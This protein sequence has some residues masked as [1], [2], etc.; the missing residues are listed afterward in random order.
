MQS[1][2]V[3]SGDAS[4]QPEEETGSVKHFHP[5]TERRR[6]KMEVKER[7]TSHLVDLIGQLG[8]DGDPYDAVFNAVL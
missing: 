4:C 5:N 6:R 8:Q 7:R 1:S 3:W 2:Y